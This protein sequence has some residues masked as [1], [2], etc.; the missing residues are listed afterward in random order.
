[1]DATKPDAFAIAAAFI[2]TI[3]FHISLYY[4]V[5]AEF[6]HIKS[7]Q[8]PEE[9]KLEILPP[10]INKKR[11]E[12]IE[13]NP[14]ANQLVPQSDSPESF[15][16]QRAADELPDPTS[17]SKKPYVEGEIKDGRIGEG[18]KESGLSGRALLI[19]ERRKNWEEVSG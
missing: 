4:A 18:Q 9:L 15:T 13:A 5:P 14:Y 8:K 3:L 12:Y 16:N 19:S 11:P 10:K 6:E 7:K 2:L 1:M 17:K